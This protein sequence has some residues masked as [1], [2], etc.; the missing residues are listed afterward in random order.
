MPVR[1]AFF[2]KRSKEPNSK[3]LVLT[4]LGGSQGAS[5]FG[6][7]IPNA[8]AMIEPSLRSKIKIY[9]QARPEQIEK[10]KKFYRLLEIE[11]AVRPFFKN[12]PALFHKSNLVICR[13]GASSIAELAASGRASLMLP[14]P[15]ALD[16]HQKE[17]AI[18]MEKAGGGYCLDEKTLSPAFLA[19]R[20]IQLFESPKKLSEMARNAKALSGPNAAKNIA[21]VAEDL[22]KTPRISRLGTVA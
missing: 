4:I 20:I 5:I 8:I 14:L 1:K 15:S 9:Q 7:L 21:D 16:D 2:V 13:S 10:I 12:M 19:T 17:N 6:T 22:I 18:Q 11:A 3:K